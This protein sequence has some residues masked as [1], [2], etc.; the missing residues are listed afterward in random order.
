M[1]LQNKYKNILQIYLWF[2][3]QDIFVKILYKISHYHR[4]KGFYEANSL[5]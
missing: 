2:I 1:L 3:F 4:L 5:R